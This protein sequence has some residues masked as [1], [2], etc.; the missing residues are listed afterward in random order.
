M[1]VVPLLLLLGLYLFLSAY[2]A[3]VARLERREEEQTLQHSE[4]RE[5][6]STA[7]RARCVVWFRPTCIECFY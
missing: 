2:A 7:Q 4:V 3:E 1:L 6:V 5:S